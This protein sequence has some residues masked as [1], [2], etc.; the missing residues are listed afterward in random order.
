[1]MAYTFRRAGLGDIDAL[2][3]LRADFMACFGPLDEK[4]RE[5]LG[6]YGAFLLESM[7]DGSF[8]QW[9]AEEDG[10]IAATGSISFYRLP[11]TARRPNGR[12]CYIG[13]MFTYPAHRNRGLAG[14]ILRRLADEARAAGCHAMLLHASDQGRPLYEAFGFAASQSMMEYRF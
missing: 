6:N 5:A 14:E 12:A 4:G 7:A 11:P 3:R 13:N 8:V 10:E 9:L 1:M 2:V